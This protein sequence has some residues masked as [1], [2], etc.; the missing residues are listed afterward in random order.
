[1]KKL[2]VLLIVFSAAACRAELP[3]APVMLDVS[4][5]SDIS[6]SAQVD[7]CIRAE[8]LNS[9]A[10]LDEGVEQFQAYISHLYEADPALGEQLI[11]TV[12]EA[13][14]A[15]LAFRDADCKVEAFE[16]EEGTLLQQS[17]I[18]SCVVRM[19]AERTEYLGKLL[20]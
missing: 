2:L 16:A 5:C 17:L 7:D 13:H 10:V 4:D 6:A 14:R 8:R 3:E 1:M 9:Q 18:N 12:A 11:E 19:N 20:R 15:W